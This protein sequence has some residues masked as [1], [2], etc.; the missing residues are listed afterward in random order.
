MTNTELEIL[1][2]KW[3][4]ITENSSKHSHNE[5]DELESY[6]NFSYLQ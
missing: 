1:E 6:Y 5:L 4:E 2:E 3:I